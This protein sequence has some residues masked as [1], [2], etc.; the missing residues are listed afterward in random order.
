MT[1]TTTTTTPSAVAVEAQ[2]RASELGAI[3]ALL[4]QKDAHARL[5]GLERTTGADPARVDLPR[6][7]LDEMTTTLWLPMSETE[8]EAIRAALVGAIATQ[9][10]EMA[11]ELPL[12]EEELAVLQGLASAL[13]VI[14]RAKQN[15]DAAWDRERTRPAPGLRAPNGDGDGDPLLFQGVV[16]PL[17]RAEAPTNGVVVREAPGGPTKQNP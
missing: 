4:P 10:H 12:D 2:R 5:I 1:T 9:F 15:A 13:A 3:A 7:L 8:A 14:C 11:R 16:P 17:S 6:S